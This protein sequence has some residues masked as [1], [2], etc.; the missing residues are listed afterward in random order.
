MADL[1][2]TPPRR[3]AAIAHLRRLREHDMQIG[4]K[5]SGIA[6]DIGMLLYER[7]EGAL[8]VQDITA[9][10]GYSGPTVRLVLRRLQRAKALT[11]TSRQG[12]TLF[13]ALTAQ[14]VAGFDTYCGTICA[15]AEQL[16]LLDE[17][18]ATAAVLQMPA[19]DRRSGPPLPPAPHA[20]VQPDRAAAD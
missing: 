9:A 5:H 8:C 14:G 17:A 10:T 7:S 13:Y 19:P 2:L 11:L 6:L 18:P 12:R 4:I 3:A 20:G 15:F 16:P 1:R